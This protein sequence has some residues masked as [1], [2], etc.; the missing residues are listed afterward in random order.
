M[1][2]NAVEG[3]PASSKD[4]ALL[5]VA[6]HLVLDGAVAAARAVGATEAVVA[7]GRHAAGALAAVRRAIAERPSRPVE[8]QSVAVASGFVAGE[9]TALLQAL[10]G[11]SSKPTLKPPYPFERGLGGAPTLVSNAETFAHIALIARYGSE[12]YRSIGTPDGPG[13]ALVTLSGAV[14]QP[15]VREVALGSSVDEVI[16]TAGGATGPLSAVLVGGYFGR[17]YA[18]AAAASL[19]LTPDVMGAGAIVLFPER[20]CAVRE[21]ARVTAYLAEQSAGQCGPCVYGLRA[22]ADALAASASTDR[23]AALERF[24]TQ[25]VGRG[26]CRH[27]D[28]VVEFVR[29]ALEVFDDEF[30]AHAARGACGRRHVPVLPF[31][32]RRAA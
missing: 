31:A 16:G 30:R 6:P 8:V 10:A 23:R 28:G 17:W 9:E 22:V 24:S 32:E 26:A 18:P 1:V 20:A 15:G 19:A 27:P 2:V 11:R 21:V 25:I 12:W 4:R 5:E 3:E 29:S 7:V 13:T 14:A